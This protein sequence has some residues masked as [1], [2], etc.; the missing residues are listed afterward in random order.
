[1]ENGGRYRIIVGLE[2]GLLCLLAF[3][4]ATLLAGRRAPQP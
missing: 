2:F 3:G 4:L 1:M